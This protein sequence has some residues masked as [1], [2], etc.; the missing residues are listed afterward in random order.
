MSTFYDIHCKL[1]GIL[2]TNLDML[3]LHSPLP[4]HVCIAL[5]AEVTGTKAAGRVGLK[6]HQA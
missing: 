1:S 6:P 4:T 2:E 5:M 3:C